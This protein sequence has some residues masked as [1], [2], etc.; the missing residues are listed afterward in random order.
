MAIGIPINEASSRQ[1]Q[2]LAIV[3]KVS[4]LLSFLSSAYVIYDVVRM[5][6]TK[7]KNLRLFHSIRFG[8]SV[9]DSMASAAWFFTTW[10]IPS[11]VLPVYG[12]R[13]TQG[14]C[15]AQGFFTQFSI[16][17]VFY[18]GFLALY[19]LL[20]IKFGWT[21]WRLKKARLGPIVHAVSLTFGLGTSTVCLAL[22]LL[23][24][25]GWDCWISAVPLGCQ[26]RWRNKNGE[27]TCTRGDNAN[28]YQWIFFYLPLWICAFLVTLAMYMVY[29]T[30][31]K[32]AKATK[33]WQNGKSQVQAG[34]NN[35]VTTQAL[36]YA[37]SFYFVW[38]FPTILRI[39]EIINDGVLLYHWVFLSAIFLPL[40]GL[41]NLFIYLR[42]QLLE[43]RKKRVTE[44]ARKKTATQAKPE[45]RKEVLGDLLGECETAEPS[46]ETVIGDY[47]AESATSL[48]LEEDDQ[49]GNFSVEEE[50]GG[51]PR[52]ADKNKSARSVA[53]VDRSS[54][55]VKSNSVRSITSNLASKMVEEGE[56]REGE[57]GEAAQEEI[58][59]QKGEAPYDLSM[60]LVS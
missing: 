3:P 38:L 34:R 32:S 6:C 7:R 23:N 33:R 47:Q 30:Y 26:E 25:I 18:S 42:P 57:E 58:R 60:S 1:M 8:M 16:A 19:H 11:A 27:T 51:R 37:G 50:G 55:G 5:Y 54:G 44:R 29:S 43:R 59:Q 39:H 17:T 24:P 36:L 15:A 46:K 22:G 49:C 40:Q 35:L 12:A 13:G 41:L 48:Y 4:S 45:T 20:V 2:A 21:E 52:L 28:L 53:S 14:T 56:E 31:S 9:C 10:P